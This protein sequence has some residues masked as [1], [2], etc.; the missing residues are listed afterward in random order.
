M[1]VD[2]TAMI[3]E[4]RQEVFDQLNAAN[5]DVSGMVEA[6]ENELEFVFSDFFDRFDE[7][8]H[9]NGIALNSYEGMM[10]EDESFIN[11]WQSEFL[12]KAIRHWH[13]K[14]A[15]RALGGTEPQ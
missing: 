10:E 6:I 9:D 8:F 1:S 12:N 7:Y 4:R 15:A 2:P 5:P 3:A 13:H 14:L 11:D